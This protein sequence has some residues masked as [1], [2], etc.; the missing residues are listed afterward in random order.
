MA[1]NWT[2]YVARYTAAIRKNPTPYAFLSVWFAFVAG[3]DFRNLRRGVG[4]ERYGFLTFLGFA[5]LL[6]Y[7]LARTIRELRDHDHS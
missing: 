2:S 3:M 6:S 1:W 5:L 7:F 4:L